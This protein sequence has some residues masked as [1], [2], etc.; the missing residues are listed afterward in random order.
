M[1]E[2]APEAFGLV[3]GIIERKHRPRPE[4]ISVIEGIMPGWVFVDKKAHPDVALIWSKGLEGFHFCGDPHCD[5]LF[6]DING[7][8]DGCLGERMI[9]G[10]MDCFEASGDPGWEA[11]MPRLFA[12]REMRHDKQLVYTSEHARDL[13][14]S[15]NPVPNGFFLVTIEDILRHPERYEN[16]EFVTSIIEKYWGTAGKYAAKGVG[17]C[18]TTAARV[19]SI[20]YSGCM[21]DNTHV[22]GIETEETHRRKGLAEI[23]AQALLQTHAELGVLSHWDCMEDNHASSCLAEKLGLV[24]AYA[25]DL[26]WFPIVV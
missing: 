10:G 9:R 4:A 20:A 2:L 26:F 6:Q 21:G 1:I 3:E 12:S 16:P 14:H 19:V 7:L 11:T 23:V 24:K 8:I 5:A 22:I 18:M 15:V 25:Y 13:V 17:Y